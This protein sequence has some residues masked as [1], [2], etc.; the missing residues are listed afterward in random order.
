MNFRIWNPV[1]CALFASPAF[2]Q[3]PQPEFSLQY[4]GMP[5]YALTAVV[6]LGIVIGFAYL[7][8]WLASLPGRIAARRGH[9]Q[10]PA[11]AICGWMGVITLVFW[12]VAIVWAYTMTEGQRQKQPVVSGDDLASLR[13]ALSETA[14]RVAAIDKALS[15]E[16]GRP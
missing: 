3:A 2:A 10:A 8:Y 12:P 4:M 7:V 6:L 15:S 1:F 11:I 9:P 13:A 5:I 14:A 16:G